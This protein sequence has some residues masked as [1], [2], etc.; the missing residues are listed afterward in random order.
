[1]CRQPVMEPR[2]F[3]RSAR[4]LISTWAPSI[5]YCLEAWPLKI[6]YCLH[7]LYGPAHFVGQTINS[8]CMCTALEQEQLTVVQRSRARTADS[9]TAI[10]PLY[11]IVPATLGA[12]RHQFAFRETNHRAAVVSTSRMFLNC[13]S[14]NLLQCWNQVSPPGR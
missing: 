7:V 13:G 14:Q 2:F 1:V 11:R 12:C 9:C 10:S 5:S 4:G 6:L 3:G 8:Q